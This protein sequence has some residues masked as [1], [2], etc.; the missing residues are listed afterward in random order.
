MTATKIPARSII[1][2]VAAADGVTWLPISSL[3]SVDVDPSSDSAKVD[4][5][6]FDSQGTY[7]GRAMQRGA[8]MDING[9]LVKDDTTG[10]QDTGQLRLVTL[11]K[12]VAEASIGLIRFRHPADV[13]WKQWTFYCEEQK[14]GGKNNDESSWGV[15]ITRSGPTV[16]TTAP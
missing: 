8:A 4:T 2:Q 13:Q 3:T 14:F 12:A 16:L 1:V 9:F 10:V 6:T 11:A 7:E 15:K 5:T